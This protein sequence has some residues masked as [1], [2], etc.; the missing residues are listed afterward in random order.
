MG[1]FSGSKERPA[2]SALREVLEALVIA[3]VLAFLI[4]SFVMAP[5][6]IPSESMMPTLLIQDHLFVN[7]LIYRFSEPQ[8]GDILVFKYPPDRKKDLI[9]RVIGLPGEKVEIRD[10]KVYIDGAELTEEY[11]PDDMVINGTF[12]PEVVDADSYLMLGDNRNNSAD[13]RVWGEL[14]KKDIIGR[15]ELIYW[16]LDR[17]R[18]LSGK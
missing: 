12:G 16:P 10:G 6:Y 1:F 9:K 14:H 3:L 4:R 11:L 2:K 13:S 17:I 15:A 5:F 18:L 7:K 8:R